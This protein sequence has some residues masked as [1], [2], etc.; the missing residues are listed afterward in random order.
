MTVEMIINQVKAA[1][2]CLKRVRSKG[3]IVTA[4]NN[5]SGKRC[6][7]PFGFQQCGLFSIDNSELFLA[8]NQTMSGLVSELLVQFHMSRFSTFASC[9]AF[10]KEAFGLA[11][12]VI[13]DARIR[14][15]D[16]C[17]DVQASYS[18]IRRCL[19]QPRARVSEEIRSGRSTLYLGTW[20]RQTCCYQKELKSDQL[21]YIK[22]KSS[23]VSGDENVSAIR[24]E[25]RH[26]RNRV[27][28]IALREIEQLRDFNPF[29]HLQLNTIKRVPSSEN[30][31]SK[32][33]V[34]IDAYLHRCRELGAHEA[35]KSFNANGNFKRTIGIH[36]KP[37]R[38]CFKKAWKRR[39]RRFL[40]EQEIHFPP[41]L[42]DFI[43]FDRFCQKPKSLLPQSSFSRNESEVVEK[44]SE[45]VPS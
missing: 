38:L 3:K 29:A 31:S 22:K 42:N 10:L 24:I 1:T 37:L 21:D 43:I 45:A 2:Y 23:R 14:R 11:F 39:M 17:I 19:S 32:T 20:P 6:R 44:R 40:G 15:L 5:R 36:L 41:S 26:K 9:V 7:L 33:K 18:A 16:C 4:A 30:I 35:R 34:I 8:W 27:P 12:P 28:I 25:V 13:L